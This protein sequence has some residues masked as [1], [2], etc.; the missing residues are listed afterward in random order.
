MRT[1]LEIKLSQK[2]VY[3]EK[4]YQ[5]SRKAWRMIQHSQPMENMVLNLKVFNGDVA[6]Q[7]D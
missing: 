2:A 3:Q 6:K 4:P 1:R 5:W 7:S